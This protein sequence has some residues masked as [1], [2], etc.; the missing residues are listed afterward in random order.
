M[1]YMRVDPVNPDPVNPHLDREYF[2][3]RRAFLRE[4]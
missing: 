4:Q 3:H 2:L 1:V